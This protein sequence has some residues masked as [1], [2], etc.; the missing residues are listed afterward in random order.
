MSPLDMLDALIGLMFVYLVLS[1]IVTALVEVWN[2]WYGLRGRTLHD[3][4][5]RLFCS[6]SLRGAFYAHPRILA[7]QDKNDRYPSYIRDELFAEVLL[8]VM[9]GRR[10]AELRQ[11]PHQIATAIAAKGEEYGAATVITLLNGFL[12][13]AAGDS[14]RLQQLVVAWFRDTQER[15]VGWFRRKLSWRLLAVGLV[16]TL[17]TNADTLHIFSVLTADP[18]LRQQYVES[19]ERALEDESLRGC[20]AG[21]ATGHVARSQEGVQSPASSD[22]AWLAAAKREAVQLTPLLG[23]QERVPVGLAWF[24]AVIGWALTAIALSL[25]APFWFDMLQKI[26]RV[27]GSLRPATAGETPAGGGPAPSDS[28]SAAN[29]GFAAPA[30]LAAAVDLDDF[31][32]FRPEAGRYELVNAFW[33]TRFAE[34]AYRSDHEVSQ[35]CQAWGLQV[36][37]ISV[38]GDQVDSQIFV[39][40][41][42]RLLVVGCRGTELSQSGDILTNLQC[43]LETC[44]WMP[45]ARIH[46]GFQQALN[47]AWPTLR[48]LI[49]NHHRNRSV[50]L[51]GHSL[52]GALAVLAGHRL[53]VE[54]QTAPAGHPLAG[55]RIGGLYV[56]GQPRCGD[57]NFARELEA[58]LGARLVR[59]VNNRDVIPLSPLAAMGYT[60][61][62]T[63]L[64]IDELGRT[65]IDP[66]VWYKVLDKLELDP[67]QLRARLKEMVGDHGA[68]L[69]LRLLG[70]ALRRAP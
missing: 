28:I 5:G 20:L 68:A 2:E 54:S 30:A 27:R 23:W 36:Q 42:D 3:A 25:G 40:W 60:H 1:L 14:Q 59:I 62:G 47:A 8:D 50:W 64:Y 15:A 34:L 17:A 12:L 9:T 63:V 56:C 51:T 45:A 39:T 53:L 13:E 49:E 26:M 16:V 22:C 21:E 52:G 6:D 18:A 48:A 10:Y 29:T 44:A 43:G 4:L 24:W 19:V 7:L 41:S 66:P 67:D 31:A 69:Y 33:M 70:E 57:A 11:S 32:G 61:A 65:V 58:R 35:R 55:L 37:F 46:A 38:T